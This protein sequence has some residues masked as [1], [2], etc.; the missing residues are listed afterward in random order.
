MYFPMLNLTYRLTTA[1]SRD[2]IGSVKCSNMVYRYTLS[3]DSVI[4]DEQQ[5]YSYVDGA[6]VCKSL[7]LKPGACAYINVCVTSIFRIA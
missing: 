5:I 6:G 2:F 4:Y 1:H 7:S 3:E